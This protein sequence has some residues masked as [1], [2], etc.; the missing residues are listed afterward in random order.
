[1]AKLPQA[2]FNSNDPAHF[3]FLDDTDEAPSETEP[4]PD[5]FPPWILHSSAAAPRPVPVKPVNG[6]QALDGDYRPMPLLPT[7]VRLRDLLRSDR[8]AV[9]S[10]RINL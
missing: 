2:D 10:Y 5:L 3:E 4:S 1:M 7:A 9:A 8:L 6:W